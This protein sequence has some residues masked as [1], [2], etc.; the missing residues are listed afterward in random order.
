MIIVAEGNITVRLEEQYYYLKENQML[1]I[2]PL[3]YHSITANEKGRYRRITALFDLNAIP[4]LLQGEFTKQ[5]KETT[6]EANQIKKIKKICQSDD[7]F[8]TRHCYKV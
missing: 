8:F 3:F 2:P 1:V 6:I 7:P 4:E 5:G